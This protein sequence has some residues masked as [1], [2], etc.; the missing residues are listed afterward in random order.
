MK[1]IIA[2]LIIIF[3]FGLATTVASPVWAQ[4]G[5]QR[6][7][8]QIT[9][10]E[11]QASRAAA[12]S[13]QEL[14]NIQKTAAT[15]INTRIT[16]LQTLLTRLNS[17]TRLSSDEKA[18][19]TTDINT[20]INGLQTLLTKI[21]ADTDVTTARADRKSIITSYYVYKYFEPKVRLLLV[22]DNLQM[23][24]NNVANLN[25][26]VGAT[27]NNLPNS[28]NKTALQGLVADVNTQLTTIN[29]H[30][31]SDKTTIVALT[32]Q[33]TD[34]E[35]TFTQVRQDL[36]QI[37]REDFAKIRA[38]FG[39]MQGLVIQLFKASANTSPSSTP[40]GASSSAH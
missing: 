21:Q 11:N 34:P 36:A 17:D 28:A 25:G 6:V 12:V 9:R 13:A 2:S 39:Q 40:T 22:I 19:L 7:V 24:S 4:L 38:D 37:V 33:S 32:V 23:L 35:T 30:L 1:K 26:S 27:I 8:N 29:N 5:G 14:A 18:S 16:S 3:A 15:L 31:T 10:S 20:T